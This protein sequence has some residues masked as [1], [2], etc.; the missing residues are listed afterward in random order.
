MPGTRP[1]LAQPPRGLG[2]GILRRHS[3]ET[4]GLIVL[5]VSILLLSTGCV[6]ASG[7][8]NDEL[9][10]SAV[11]LT[12]FAAISLSEAF[13]EIAK[14]FEAGNPGVSVNLNLAGSQRL[15]TQLEHGAHGDVFASADQR[16]MSLAKASG[17]LD[18]KPVIFAT[19]GLVVIVPKEPNRVSVLSERVTSVHK[20]G[21]EGIK[22]ALALPD[23]PAGRYSRVMIA[24]LETGETPVGLHLAA[25][26]MAN[27]VTLEPSVRGV[28]TKVALGEVD[29]GVV[30]STDAGAKYVRDR[31]RVIP[32]P[33][34]SN[35]IAEYPI[36]ALN[37]ARHPRTAEE[38]ILFVLSPKGQSV[39][40]SHGFGPA[41]SR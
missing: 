29:A 3:P 40:G 5:V 4:H 8:A 10:G 2:I 16:Q 30:Y 33:E 23:V 6:P 22:L 25:R 28:A 20:L 41:A 37:E 11:E 15:R 35:V 26:I 17:V 24:N 1:F 31:V 21:D 9:S 38:F 14:E 19:N 7:A 13:T 18:G 34:T 27:V 32:I 36:A 12:V 39:L